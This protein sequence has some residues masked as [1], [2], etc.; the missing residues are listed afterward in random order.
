M[1]K[2]ALPNMEFSFSIQ[3]MGEESGMNWVGDFKYKRPTLM[4]RSLIAVMRAQLNGDLF[5][6][7]TAAQKINEALAHLK[8]TIFEAPEWWT[9]SK[10]GAELYDQNVILEIY[11]KCVEFEANWKKKIHSGNAEDVEVG[12]ETSKSSKAS[13]KPGS[14]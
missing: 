5:T 11:N 13:A 7:D 6:V 8:F 1:K 14:R 12:G 2:Y 3:V 9:E 10:S 4:D